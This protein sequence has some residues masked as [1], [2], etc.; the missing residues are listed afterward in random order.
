MKQSLKAFMRGII[1]YAGLFPPA[2]LPLDTAIHNY[3]QYRGESDS[4]I[5]SRFIIPASQLHELEA[6][7][8]DMRAGGES[9]GFSV[10]GK[11][12]KTTDGFSEEIQSVIQ[13]CLDFLEEHGEYATTDVLEIK[14]PE[15]AVQANDTSM[16]K[17][18]LAETARSVGAH[19]Q[20]PDSVFYEVVLNES[21]QKDLETAI[22]AISNHNTSDTGVYSSYSYAGF[23]LRCGGVEASMFPSPG[24]IAHA[25][26]TARDYE[27]PVKCTA[28]LHHPV[29]HFNGSVQTKMHGFFNVFGGAILTHVHDLSDEAFVEILREEDPEQFT[30][31]DESFSWNDL[32]VATSDIKKLR[33]TALISYGSCSFDEPREDLKKLGL[34]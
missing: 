33:A 19:A 34:L 32:A 26:N 20:L 12:R 24:Q 29:R 1:D 4:W 6:Y 25:L 5:L 7:R 14:L 31:S 30:F 17:E 15:E 3:M 10:L 9:I 11:A 28:G 2:E 22:T 16:L 27:V 18:L 23:K 21:W 8:T 13:H